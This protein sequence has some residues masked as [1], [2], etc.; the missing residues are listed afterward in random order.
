MDRIPPIS[1]ERLN[2]LT[3]RIHPLVRFAVRDVYRR[4]LRPT[5]PD[6]RGL[7]FHIK[8]VHPRNIAFTWDPKP[9]GEPLMGLE[10]FETIRTYHTW[11]APALFKPSVAE[12][13]AQLTTG[14]A[15]RAVGFEILSHNLDVNNVLSDGY[16]T[17]LTKLYEV[18]H[19]S[20][21]V[22]R[23]RYHKDKGGKL[24]DLLAPKQKDK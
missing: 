6:S 20:Q 14:Q 10:T 8:P 11:G 4:D 19:A 22:K 23:Y 13:L 17:V 24:V 16:H 12:V 21:L 2:E 1:D 9:I 3:A 15:E 5:E 18:A 7:L